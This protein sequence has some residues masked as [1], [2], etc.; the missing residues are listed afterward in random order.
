LGWN[1][2]LATRI[3]REEVLIDSLN[4]DVPQIRPHLKHSVPTPRL[5]QIVQVDLAGELVELLQRNL[6]ERI[7]KVLLDKQFFSPRW[8]LP[9]SWPLSR[10]KSDCERTSR[11]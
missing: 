3:L 8:F 11:A 7:D 5:R 10:A 1:S 2:N 6:V 9:S 4:K